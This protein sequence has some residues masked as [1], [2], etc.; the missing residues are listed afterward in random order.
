M[1]RY[2][3]R[4]IAHYLNQT[5]ER[6][7]PFAVVPVERLASVL[8]PGDVLL[9]EGNRRISTAIKYL[10]QSTWSHAALFVGDF[11]RTRRGLE[12]PTLDISPYFRVIKPE[13]EFGFDY[14]TLL[15]SEDGV[16]ERSRVEVAS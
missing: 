14:R 3:G 8:E 6:Y 4:K 1:L 13:I 9:V 16:I 5:I 10:T 12:A 2:L 15:W 7:E 11:Q